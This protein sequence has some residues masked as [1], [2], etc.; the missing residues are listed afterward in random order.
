MPRWFGLVRRRYMSA[1]RERDFRDHGAGGFAGFGM[2]GRARLLPSERLRM[3]AVVSFRAFDA[4]RGELMNRVLALTACRVVRDVEPGTAIVLRMPV[5]GF[6][7]ERATAAVKPETGVLLSV[8]IR[9][10]VRTVGN[11]LLHNGA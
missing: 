4:S 11:A 3:I 5:N 9:G 1:E 10:T 8:E 2:A 6:A 7:L